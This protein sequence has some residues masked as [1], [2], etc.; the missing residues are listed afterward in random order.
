MFSKQHQYVLN[1]VQLTER[2]KICNVLKLI[3]NRQQHKK[4]IRTI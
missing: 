4:Y 1:K 2:K 3:M